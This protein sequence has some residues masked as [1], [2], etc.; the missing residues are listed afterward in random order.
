MESIKERNTFSTLW[1]V[2][3]IKLKA[4]MPSQA[5]LFFTVL[6]IIWVTTA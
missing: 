4:T 6:Y 1:V 3:I 2:S 5:L